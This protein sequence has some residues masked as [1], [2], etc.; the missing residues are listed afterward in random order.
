MRADAVAK[1]LKFPRRS[2]QGTS[3]APC[4]MMRRTSSFLVAST[5]ALNTFGAYG[6]GADLQMRAMR[7]GV[8]RRS[9]ARKNHS[10]PAQAEHE[11]VAPAHPSVI[12]TTFFPSR[13]ATSTKA[14]TSSGSCCSAS[15]GS[16]LYDPCHA[17][18]G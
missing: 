18:R 11:Q 1:L 15:S 14:R 7:G 12:A 3:G 10:Q 8:R 9:E 2:S 5:A 6:G 4:R 17:P 16:S 13:F